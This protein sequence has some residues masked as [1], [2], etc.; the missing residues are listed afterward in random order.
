M[1][2][3]YWGLLAPH[4][5]RLSHQQLSSPTLTRQRP[6]QPVNRRIA[7]RRRLLGEGFSPASSAKVPGGGTKKRG[8]RKNRETPF[9]PLS[10]RPP[11]FMLLSSGSTRPQ[12]D[13]P[14]S[15]D[16]V[17]ALEQ[18]PGR[19]KDPQRPRNMPRPFNPCHHSPLSPLEGGFLLSP[20]G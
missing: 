6:V 16:T 12:Q 7:T 13:P 20:P 17:S 4:C 8:E 14:C 9:S 2:E 1:I 18:I 11:F 15:F 10:P 19:A 3:T 5:F